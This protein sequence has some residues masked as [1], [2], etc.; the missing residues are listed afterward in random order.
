MVEQARLVQEVLQEAAVPLVLVVRSDNKATLDFRA[1]V[2]TLV[3]RE[4]E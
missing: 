1:L 3:L 2:V 4:Q